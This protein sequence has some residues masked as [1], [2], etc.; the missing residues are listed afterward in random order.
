M[1]FSIIAVAATFVSTILAQT[2]PG[3]AAP[4]LSPTN[5]V[6]GTVW[7]KGQNATIAWKL[8]SVTVGTLP[9]QLLQGNDPTHLTV[10]TKVGDIDVAAKGSKASVPVPDVPSGYYTLMIGQYTFSHYFLIEDKTETYTGTQPLATTTATTTI[11][12]TTT[13]TTTS[14]TTTIATTTTATAT[15]TNKAS[16]ATGYLKVG[17]V[18]PLAASAAVMIA[19][20]LAI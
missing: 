2:A 6:A 8:G 15:P 5:P 10:I 11:V 16:A 9:V 19:A 17:N 4:E 13:A 3:P 1:R 14:A 12:T 18:F 20:A 7:R